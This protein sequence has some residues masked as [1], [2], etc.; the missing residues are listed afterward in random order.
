MQT[1]AEAVR[2]LLATQYTQPGQSR[3]NSARDLGRQTQTSSR[4]YPTPTLTVFW[5][6]RSRSGPFLEGCEHRKGI[7]TRAG[8]TGSLR[9]LAETPEKRT[10]DASWELKF[11]VCLRGGN[12]SRELIAA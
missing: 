5:N 1:S 7:I 12:E 2:R 3:A 8:H 6:A 9:A 4:E 10:R 11:K